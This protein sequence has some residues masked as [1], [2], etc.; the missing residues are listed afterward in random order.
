MLDWALNWLCFRPSVW[1]NVNWMGGHEGQ[2]VSARA[3][4]EHWPRTERILNILCW[5][6]ESHHCQKA[7]VRWLEGRKV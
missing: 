5:P 7:Y 3:W 1:I 2:P 4:I 6:Y